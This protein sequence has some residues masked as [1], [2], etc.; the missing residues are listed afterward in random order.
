[1]ATK[2]AEMTVPRSPVFDDG[3]GLKHLW[4]VLGLELVGFARLR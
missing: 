2:W 3:R 4:P 1:M